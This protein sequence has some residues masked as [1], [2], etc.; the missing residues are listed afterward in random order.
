[1]T[2]IPIIL[3]LVITKIHMALN[4]VPIPP[5]IVNIALPTVPLQP[6]WKVIRKVIF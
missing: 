4:T 1:M 5:T 2:F 3:S 6:R